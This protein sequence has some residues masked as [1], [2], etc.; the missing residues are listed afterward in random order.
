[1]GSQMD[2]DVRFFL[3]GLYADVPV[4]HKEPTGRTFRDY[5]QDSLML[6]ADVG[7]GPVKFVCVEWCKR[8]ISIARA[9]GI[10]QLDSVLIRGEP[11]SVH[12]MSYRKSIGRNFRLIIESGRDPA[13]HPFAIRRFQQWPLAIKDD[14]RQRIFDQVVMINSN[15]ISFVKGEFYS[16]RRRCVH[17]IK[18]ICLFG[19]D[20]NIGALRRVR[21]AI[22][23]LLV[24]I[25]GLQLPQI[26][27][28][29]YWF[30]RP[31]EEIASPK[32]KSDILRLYAIALVIENHSEFLTEKIFDAF[33]N[34]CIPV[35]V[36]PPPINFGI[37]E[38]LF[39]YSDPNIE[40]I[41]KAIS[42]A[43]L[44]DYDLWK[45]RTI[46]WMNSQ[47]TRREWSCETVFK[48]TSELILSC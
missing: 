1:M 12:P 5:F 9:R 19:R 39:V 21:I 44:I 24:C 20:W 10:G 47:D 38:D 37:P 13:L 27:S 17:Q 7:S 14:G 46:K 45:M 8:D 40:A 41:R 6:D 2:V 42:T 29:V 4:N 33:A 35:Y 28:L 25:R 22:I 3:G 30:R 31:V 43:K 34:L 32:S 36:G 23:F 15:Q 26:S 16:L 48:Q 11:I 18:E